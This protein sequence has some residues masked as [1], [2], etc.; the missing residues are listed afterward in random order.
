MA[1]STD[2]ITKLYEI[3]LAGEY[4][5]CQRLIEESA[6]APTIADRLALF[7]LMGSE[8]N[9]FEVLAGVVS[10]AGVDPAEAVARHVKVFEDFHRVTMPSSWLEVLVKMYIG[11]GLAEDFFH[12]LAHVLPEEAQTVLA[13]AM[14]G[15]A[16]SSFAK[17]EV[18]EA[19]RVH[20]ERAA[21]LKLWSRRLLG[22]A[23]THMQWLLAED[24]DVTDLLFSGNA[25]L[26]AAAGFFD[27][28]AERHAQRMADLGL[29]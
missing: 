5:A 24:D 17:D 25:A 1:T 22:E 13:Q 7:R 23:I 3:L 8:M 26:A 11:D 6:M 14:S 9:H 20:P 28:L 18:R 19:I 15:T 16:S 10:Q 2:P 4:A 29:S 21:P 27:S 12:E